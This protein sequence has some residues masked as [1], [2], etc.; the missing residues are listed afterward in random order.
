MPIL[1]ED[2]LKVARLARLELTPEELELFSKDLAKI[3]SYIDQLKKV[4]T[5][6]IVPR[7]RFIKAE[8]MLREDIVK[9]SL[10][11][12]VALANAPDRDEDFFRVPKVLG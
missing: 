1:K 6:G 10:P 11:K 7:K 9:P 12:E 4:N 8:N 2:I 3:I 5:D